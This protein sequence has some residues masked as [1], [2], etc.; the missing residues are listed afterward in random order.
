MEY[1]QPV[2]E[3]AGSMDAL[4]R[5]SCIA[6]RGYRVAQ[7]VHVGASRCVVER[8]AALVRFVMHSLIAYLCAIACVSARAA[9]S[10]GV[11]FDAPA[12]VRDLLA[13]HVE[14]SR[15]RGHERMNPDE[16]RRLYRKA[17]EEI[18]NL[19]ATEGY[20]RPRIDASMSEEGGSLRARF[21]VDPGEPAKVATVDIEFVGAIATDGD[22]RQKTERWR[23][24]W[25]LKSGEVFRHETWEAGKRALMRELALDRYPIAAI[26]KSQAVVDPA[27]NRVRLSVV[28]D[29]G[30]F[31]RFGTLAI[32]GIDRYPRSIVE[33]L[34][35]IRP[36][37]PYSV[38]QL[39][40]F[41]TRLLDS[42]YF[43]S[44]T[45]DAPADSDGTATVRVWVQERE[46]RRIAFGVGYS[47]DTGARIQAEYRQ[48]NFLD[49]GLQIGAR[50]K[51]ETRARSVGA[52]LYFP[53]NARGYR[54]RLVATAE[55]E[56][57]QGTETDKI[58][59]TA[60]RARKRGDTETDVSLSYIAEEQRVNGASDKSTQALT[61]NW[62]YT[63]RRTNDPL[64]PTSG[65]L[66]NVQ[67]GGAPGVLVAEQTFLRLY[68]KLVH[69][70]RLGDDGV[71][72]LRGEVGH[73][74]ANGTSDVPSD[75]LFRTGGDRTVRG[76]A[77]QSLG[78]REGGA[79]TGGR[80]LAVASAEY[81]HWL[82]EDWGA[83]V[84][85]DTGNAADRFGGFEFK[86]GVGVGAR[87]RS[88]VGP[89]NLDIAHGLDAGK[90]RL[91]FSV[92]LAF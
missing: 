83:A 3:C 73:V 59:L 76:Y 80:A 45:V 57:I 11:E 35:P 77:Y 25:P 60:G 22:V 63:L 8:R 40:E 56:T 15:W 87:W 10:Y 28:V 17:P 78:L 74:R 90:L 1:S 6:V 82:T 92:G 5:S 12:S 30:P 29:S 58:V 65:Y 47:T 19:L 9:E 86:T 84:F 50:I 51:L 41:Q 49:R 71:L 4:K 24:G 89:L 38:L 37:E 67:I 13:R 88:P 34:N 55:N 75:F 46:P 85:V 27:D 42:G 7:R 64:F 32:E 14:L 48:L 53:T 61:A 52:D 21:R 2:E 20:Y 69:Y 26:T 18:R 43:N 79:V 91:H 54:D 70:S 31:G 72:T 81:T 33:N 36:G 23:E 39:Q 44:V 62:S 16:F 66:L 68:G